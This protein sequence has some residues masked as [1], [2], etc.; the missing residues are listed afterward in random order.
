[1]PLKKCISVQKPW[2]TS[3]LKQYQ[4]NLNV[5]KSTL[6]LFGILA[7]SNSRI[8]WWNFLLMHTI[9]SRNTQVSGKKRIKKTL[10]I[11]KESQ[12]AK[13]LSI[14][15][16][17]YTRRGSIGIPISKI[18]IARSHPTRKSNGLN[19]RFLNLPCRHFWR[20]KLMRLYRVLALSAC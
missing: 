18:K 15:L 9:L 12:W 11:I 17:I 5:L 3:T 7:A 13:E 2:L 20:K 10:L 1:M 4:N 19:F 6:N 14:V 8:F 16:F